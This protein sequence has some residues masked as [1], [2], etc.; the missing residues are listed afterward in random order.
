M[1]HINESKKLQTGL[2]N[3][4]R[5]KEEK[6]FYSSIASAYLAYKV[7]E[8]GVESDILK[9]YRGG[10]EFR[11]WYYSTFCSFDSNL[12]SRFII[13]LIDDCMVRAV[14]FALA[15]NNAV[16]VDFILHAEDEL[17][18]KMGSFYSTPDSITSLALEILDIKNGE[19]VIDN[20]S[21]V[22]S[23]L[24]SAYEKQHDARYMGV[25]INSWACGLASLRTSILAG[26]IKFEQGNAFD[27]Y[28]DE[29]ADKAFSDFPLGLRVKSLEG[30]GIYERYKN[31]IPVL[32]KG[33]SA[34]WLFNY[35][36]TELIKPNGRAVSIM[37]L[38][39]LWNT[40][41]REIRKYFLQQKKIE[42]IIVLPSRLLANTSIPVAMIVFGHGA[43]D[44]IR[45]IDASNEYIEGRRQCVLSKENIDHIMEAM[46]TDSAISRV[47]TYAEIAE[48]D[49]SF[50]V[51]RYL[52]EKE[53]IENGVEFSAIIKNIRR[54][55]QLSAT[56]L[57]K[58]VSSVPTDIQYIVPANI[59]NG[60]I[61]KDLKSL[62]QMEQR[63]ERYVVN[64]G[65]LLIAKNGYPFK[66]AVASVEHGKTLI[67]SGNLY[68]IELDENKVNP[69]FVKA[70]LESEKGQAELKNILV[71][72][73]VLSIGA[74]ELGKVQIPLISL[75]KQNE[76]A[77]KY[78]VAMDNVEY[79]RRKV[80]KAEN[81]LAEVLSNLFG[82]DIN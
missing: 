53:T 3:I 10:T 45:F 6:S 78:L 54:G 43:D 38:G 68:I 60:V 25:E 40:L 74:T 1:L 81:E 30:T 18:S 80:E 50:A 46:T 28:F 17:S 37:S 47:V 59:Q 73:T 11:A 56:E 20:C 49:F 2:A 16:L 27:Y 7:R 75:E 5:S 61:V 31:E 33:T 21:G 82:E 69:Y 77:T 57:D 9:E 12:V 4:F 64:N 66:I 41:D 14:D 72:S 24:T 70:Y 23:F 44:G 35:R 32:A 36:L 55:V 76:V 58:A 52:I 62:C 29:K 19:L 51:R 48:E 8:E 13:E 63:F 65:N 71:G 34:D 42:A 39:G 22:G 79:L 15:F 67:A 26:N